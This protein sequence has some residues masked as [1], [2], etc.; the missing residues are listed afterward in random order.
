MHEMRE[1][2]VGFIW[3]HE[4]LRARAS[5]GGVRAFFA[6]SATGSIAWVQVSFNTGVS[7][8]KALMESE[9]YERVLYFPLLGG[10]G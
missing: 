4:S 7:S 2:A 6:S 5:E 1:L 8:E 3:W 10:F 9:Y